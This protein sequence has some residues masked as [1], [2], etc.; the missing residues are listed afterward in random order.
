MKVYTI[1]NILFTSAKV[2]DDVVYKVFETMKANKVDMISASPN[3]R[4]FSAAG[5]SKK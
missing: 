3:P 1:D 2:P 5:L 4:E